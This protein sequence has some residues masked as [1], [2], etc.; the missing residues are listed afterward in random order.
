MKTLETSLVFRESLCFEHVGLPN[1]VCS[2]SGS[3]VFLCYVM[4][5]DVCCGSTSGSQGAEHQVGKG[6]PLSRHVFDDRVGNVMFVI[7]AAPVPR[8]GINSTNGRAAP[9]PR[10]RIN[11]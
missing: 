6:T 2:F 10:V 5:V 7:V 11:A 1:R 8:S 3:C 9:A 4:F